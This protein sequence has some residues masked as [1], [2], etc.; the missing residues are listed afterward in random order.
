MRTYRFFFFLLILFVG[1]FW[2]AGGTP[3]LITAPVS[4]LLGRALPAAATGE[5]AVTTTATAATATSSEAPNVLKRVYRLFALRQAVEERLDKS[6]YVVIA[7]MP[8]TLQQAVIAVEDNRFYQH[9]GLDFEGILRAALVNLQRGEISEGGSTIT[10]QLVKNLF[11]SHEQTMTRK[12]EEALLSFDMEYRYSKDQILEMYLNTI[13][14]G[15]GA[16]GIGSAAEVYF[17]KTPAELSLAEASMLAGLPNAPSLYSPYVDF[18]AAKQR[19]AVVLNAMSKYNYIS[20][21]LLQKTKTTPIFLA[22]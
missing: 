14:F 9:V 21:D 12:L 4:K 19:Q 3:E 11:L 17:G 7:E 10:Q 15:S 2:W 16:Y 6:R 20:P 13:Y 18:G 22:R 8:L 5:P 1:S